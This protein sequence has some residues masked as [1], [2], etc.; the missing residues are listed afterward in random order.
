M[1]K[2]LRCGMWDTASETTVDFATS[3]FTGGDEGR[4]VPRPPLARSDKEVKRLNFIGS[5][6]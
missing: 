4:F 1:Q 5:S 3:C 6:N 2:T